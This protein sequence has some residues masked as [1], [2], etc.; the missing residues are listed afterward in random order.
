MGTAGAGDV[1]T[2]A[3]PATSGSPTADSPAEDS[4]ATAAAAGLGR[5]PPRPPRLRRRRGVRGL[6]SP[7][8]VA[9]A[10]AE[11]GSDTA[12]G[13]GL[14]R[15]RDS[16]TGVSTG[17]GAAAPGLVSSKLPQ[18]RPLAPVSPGGA[19]RLLEFPPELEPPRRA[20]YHKT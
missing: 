19:T 3:F 18:T 15:R 4:A 7:A 5:D 13:S 14:T 20:R 12:A 17:T 2:G 6:D 9:A 11:T 1:S 10:G 8:V 16:T